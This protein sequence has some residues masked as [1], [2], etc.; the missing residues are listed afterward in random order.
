MADFNAKIN[1]DADN[2]KALRKIE[3]VEKAVNKL[4]NAVNKVQIKVN[5]AARAEQEVN[6][7]YKALERIENAALSKLPQSLQT[8][9]AYLKAANAGMGE[10]AKR[11][12]IA[13]AAV[14]DVG[15]VPFA[16]LIRQLNQ[17]K[18]LMFE[19]QQVSVKFL[20]AP[21][22]FRPRLTGANPYQKLLDGL[23]FVKVSVDQPFQ[24][25]LDGLDR[26]KVRVI[27]TERALKGL[28]DTVKRIGGAGFGGP[29]GPGGGGSG[30]GTPGALPPADY[31]FLRGGRQTLRGL[32][33]LR[34]ELSNLL[35]TTIIGSQQFRRL[36][37]AIAEVNEEIRGAQL[38]G[39]RGGSGINPGRSKNTTTVAGSIG[40]LQAELAIKEELVRNAVIGT[41]AFK[42]YSRELQQTS[43]RLEQAQSAGK[44]FFQRLTN[45]QSKLGSAVIGGGFPLITGG[46]PGSVI[47]G[48]LGGLAGGFAGS[49]A[50]S[51]IGQAFD[52]FGQKLTD[53][54]TSV[55][56][57]ADI[58]AALDTA[59]V[60]VAGSLKRVVKELEEAG[61]FAQAYAIQQSELNKAYGE[62]AVRDLTALD[63]AN[64][65][66]ADSFKRVSS[67]ILPF[68]IR[69]SAAISNITAGAVN[70]FADAVQA[71][72][73]GF[74]ALAG[75]QG[76][77]VQRTRPDFRLEG[78]FA[79]ASASQKELFANTKS[80]EARAKVIE[81]ERRLIDQINS[82]QAR[83]TQYREQR[84]RAAQELIQIENQRNSLVAERARIEA[85]SLRYQLQVQ[86]QI[87]N[88][89]LARKTQTISGQ[90][91][92]DQLSA[93]LGEAGLA[94]AQTPG[95]VIKQPEI[96]E[97]L[98][99][100]INLGNIKKVDDF[101]A[102]LEKV[103]ATS[104]ET[105]S[106][107]RIDQLVTAYRNYVD[108]L[109]QAR[110]ESFKTFEQ[111]QQ[112]NLNEVETSLQRQVDLKNAVTDADRAR[113]N[114]LFAIQD[115]E[116]RFPNATEEQLSKIKELITELNKLQNQ[117]PLQQ[118]I[119][120]TT[121]ALADTESQLLRVVQ[122]FEN[123]L[124][125]GITN[126]V[127]SMVDGSKTA[128]EAFADMLTNMGNALVQEG[129]RMI[130]QYI[131][132]GIARIFAG[133]GSSPS[134]TEAGAFDIGR[135]AAPL[136][137]ADGGPVGAGRSYIVG[138]EGQE[139]FIPG[140]S[141]TIIPNDVFEAT[142]AALIANGDVVATDEDE[143][144]A[145]MASNSSSINN[146][147]NNS[148][149]SAFNQNS[150]AI[151]N[152]RYGNSSSTS[153]SEA[154]AINNSTLQSQQLAAATALE[155]ESMQQALTTPSKMNFTYES[156]V[157][158]EQH[159][160]STE[161]HQKG[162]AMAAKKGR[163]M[164]IASLKNSV[165]ARKEV[166]M[167]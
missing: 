110:Q 154:F 59:N 50:G 75:T 2:S 155:R 13:A 107:Q 159:Y 17:A 163:D 131:A 30:G 64:Q 146:T 79:N 94:A 3:Q 11:A 25:L 121:E 60:K 86:S 54:S 20:D 127:T 23:D 52:N 91:S 97:T 101:A 111:Q 157:I 16:P 47:G 82:N 62:N 12:I 48:A 153:A 119:K 125:S 152:T 130:A 53:L 35:D 164:A 24:K 66:L 165:R 124:A 15:R 98:F 37:N 76:A 21:T 166:G 140:K 29:G 67:A 137:R 103:F 147:Y 74:R 42:K 95:S 109:G 105:I 7:L 87:R 90:I 56:E 78:Q 120:Q 118:Y 10:F 93:Q 113:L 161:Q 136:P 70:I 68:V 9:I 18:Q 34:A 132:I 88:L 123:Q 40:A 26:V 77:D 45:P 134:P 143:Q 1:L 38:L 122:I 148:T 89:E 44:G 32:R 116:K 72:V 6:R 80:R 51:G 102:A 39:Q 144:A 57:N 14:G 100:Y 61:K 115:I 5:G 128:A 49:I 104:P 63:R 65:N 150:N 112:E 41:S 22:N 4:D 126:F 27:E 36:E 69:L 33:D 31:D 133:M 85:D 46:G 139:L 135:F 92:L 99:S 117:S 129:A 114:T 149:S 55:A 81:D 84:R 160:V 71:I 108:I 19:I 58:F 158:N 138:E 96:L 73:N 83:Q 162:L 43:Q 106:K 156:T 167:A 8:V 142:K 141:G 28:G 145:A 151:N